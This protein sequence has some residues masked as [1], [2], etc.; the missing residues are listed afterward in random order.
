MRVIVTAAVYNGR[1]DFTADVVVVAL[2]TAMTVAAVVVDDEPVI[3]MSRDG[4]TEHVR[5]Y[6]EKLSAS[7]RRRYRVDKRWI[8][9][10]SS[11][12]LAATRRPGERFVRTAAGRPTPIDARNARF[13]VRTRTDTRTS[14]LRTDTHTSENIH[15][16]IRTESHDDSGTQS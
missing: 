6:F 9:P 12:R 5:E 13:V 15:K 11:G 14:T 2:I 4:D 10:C 7:S 3:L 16:A 8:R 1:D